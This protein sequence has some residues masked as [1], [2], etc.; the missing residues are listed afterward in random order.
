MEGCT[1][2]LRHICDARP[3]AKDWRRRLE[4]GG[5]HTLI[6]IWEWDFDF[7]RLGHLGRNPEDARSLQISRHARRHEYKVLELFLLRRT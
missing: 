1:G 7:G 6:I 2:E 4:R 5:E 3:N